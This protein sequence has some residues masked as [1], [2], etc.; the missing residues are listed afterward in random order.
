MSKI[1]KILLIITS[2]VFCVCEAT[3]GFKKR[4][5]IYGWAE[6]V[7]PETLQEFKEKT[8]ISPFYDVYDTEEILTAKM[9]SGNNGYDVVLPSNSEY[10]KRHLELGLY[11]PLDKQKIPNYKHLDKKVL[12]ILEKND[13]GNKYMVPWMWSAMGIGYDVDKVRAI[14]PHAPVDSLEIIFNPKYAK[15]F[16]RCGIFWSN[17][18]PEMIGLALLYLKKDPNDTNEANLELAINLIQSVK[19]YV[20]S[21]SNTEYV[22]FENNNIC[23]TIGWAAETMQ[24]ISRLKLSETLSKKNFNVILPKEGFFINIDGMVI[25]AKSNNVENAHKFINFL[26]EPHV[27]AH[28]SNNY[29]QHMN[30]NK[31]SYKYLKAE[32]K[33][34]PVLNI[35]PALFAK[36]GYSLIDKPKKFIRKRNRAW[37]YI[38]SD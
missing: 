34:N 1:C 4:V 29:T 18:G 9:L 23:I 19:K 12:K 26:L 38:L 8:G 6:Y 17:F 13:P 35:P 20:R 22:D 30:A 24:H 28:N 15:Q 37:A 25:P 10:F 3:N 32:I 7:S 33:N 2:L 21:I 14:N 11:L 5:N 27:T 16:E 31:D 36:K